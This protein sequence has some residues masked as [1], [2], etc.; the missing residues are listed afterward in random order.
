MHTSCRPGRRARGGFTLVTMVM[1]LAL[2]SVAALVVLDSVNTDVDM[3][4]SQQRTGEAR[5][6]AEGGLM[7]VLNDQRLPTMLPDLSS[8][9]LR[10]QYTPSGQSIYNQPSVHR[11]ARNYSATIDLVRVAPMMESSHNRVRAVMYQVL[12]DAEAGDGSRA[13]VEAEVYKIA[14]AR[15]GVIQPRSHAR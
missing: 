5:E 2:A 3:L 12:V 6:A 4:R 14:S 10:T 13:G 7:E 8:P 9:Q 11:G 1:L 15:A